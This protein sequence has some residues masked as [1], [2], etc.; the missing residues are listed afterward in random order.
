[1]PID[2]STKKLMKSQGFSQGSDGKWKHNSSSSGSSSSSSKSRSSRKSK[3][4]S[5]HSS[6]SG[7]REYSNMSNEDMARALA[8]YSSNNGGGSNSGTIYGGNSYNNNSLLQ[9]PWQDRLGYISGNHDAGLSEINRAK[10]VYNTKMAAGD[11]AGANAAHTY[12]NQVRGAMGLT[13]GVD[14]DATTGASLTASNYNSY[15]S[16]SILSPQPVQ[17][18][19]TLIPKAPELPPIPTYEPYQYQEFQYNPP[20][21]SIT[22]DPNDTTFIPTAKAKDRWLKQEQA[23]AEQAY[24][25]YLGDVG[26][27][28]RAYNA[29]QNQFANQA[30]LLPYSTLTASQQAELDYRDVAA[31]AAAE[32]AEHDQWYKDQLLELERMQTEYDINKPYYSPNSGN[33]S[34]NTSTSETTT[35]NDS[36]SKYTASEIKGI[37]SRHINA[38]LKAYKRPIDY[39]AGVQR[40]MESGELDYSVGME[41]LGMMQ[42]RYP[43]EESLQQQLS[44]WK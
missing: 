25:A 12:A 22:S 32:Q 18:L 6:S 3:S 7:S 30:S 29:A 13:S 35:S 33:G 26:N 21:Y 28:D 19:E 1:M 9:M 17:Q 5:R 14:Y 34:N 15:P 4:G 2:E 38:N 16:T 40:R 36:P 11:I 8:E 31:K 37:A 10:D 42:E 44:T 41:I 20:D 24:K 27:Y 39:I 43:T 23:N